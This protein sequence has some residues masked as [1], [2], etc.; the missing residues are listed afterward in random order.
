MCADSA[1]DH[2]K[3]IGAAARA[4]RLVNRCGGATTPAVKIAARPLPVTDRDELA[5]L[6]RVEPLK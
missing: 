6:I 3:S 1:G 4:M 5:E 2:R